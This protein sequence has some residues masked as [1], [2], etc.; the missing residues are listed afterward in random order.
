MRRLPMKKCRK[1]L[2]LRLEQ[3]KPV[4]TILD[5]IPNLSRSTVYDCLQRATV[6]GLTVAKIKSMSDF[7]LEQ[8]L[9]PPNPDANSKRPEPDYIYIH[10]ELAKKV[11]GVS[12]ETLRCGNEWTHPNG[13]KRSQFLRNIGH[14]ERRLS[15]P[16]VLII[17]L[18]SVY[19]LIG[20]DRLDW[21]KIPR[22]VR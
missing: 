8:V 15:T 19:T 7:D 22:P 17:S 16:C 13:Y 10:K 3:D 2:L 20:L 6:L 9:Y 14:G 12:I 1:L 18:V 21:F 5:I 11:K 4:A